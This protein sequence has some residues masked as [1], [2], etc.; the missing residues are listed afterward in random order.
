MK[1]FSGKILK[2]LGWKIVGEYPD[3]KKSISI[4]AP[5]TAHSD[6]IYG[7]LG[8]T[9]L[10]VNYRFLSKKELFFFPMNLIMKKLGSMPVRGVKGKNAIYQVTEMLN[11]ADELH[12]VVSPE[13][14]IEKVTE[15]NRG[16]YFM[17]TKAN[18]P[19][20]VTYLDYEKK[21]MGIKGVIYDVEDFQTV[22]KQ[23][24]TMYKDV[25]GKRPEQFALQTIY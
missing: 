21:E 11:N 12:I 13:G 1:T 20:V 24:N 15:W 4:F 14:W 2:L 25:K 8:Y 16:F 7:K 22:M 5:H 3:I 19:I 18:V 6:A 10:G 9:E 17:A 23:I